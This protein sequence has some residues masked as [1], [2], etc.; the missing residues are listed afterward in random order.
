[1]DITWEE[2]YGRGGDGPELDDCLGL[3]RIARIETALD[4]APLDAADLTLDLAGFGY[5]QASRRG[6]GWH[7]VTDPMSDRLGFPVSRCPV[8][9]A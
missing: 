1:M 8:V 3:Q 7:V 6:G 4:K 2:G 5:L 9:R